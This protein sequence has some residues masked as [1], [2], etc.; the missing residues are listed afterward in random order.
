MTP[1]LYINRENLVA[2]FNDA[3]LEEALDGRRNPLIERLKFIAIYGTKP[4]RVLHDP[5]RPGHAAGWRPRSTSA[6]TT[7]TPP[8]S[9]STGQPA[10]ATSLAR[11]APVD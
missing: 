5:H 2:E 6:P 4:R 11:N 1:S 7:A 9:S 3:P 10:S 8:K